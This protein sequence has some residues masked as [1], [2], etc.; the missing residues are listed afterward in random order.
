MNAR[1]IK[2]FVDGLS[3]V[4]VE[5]VS[6]MVQ[7][8]IVAEARSDSLSYANLLVGTLKVAGRPDLAASIA[9]VM[10]DI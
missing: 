9:N 10:K 2:E 7:R 4:E 6:I 8:R 3:K 1:T 5:E